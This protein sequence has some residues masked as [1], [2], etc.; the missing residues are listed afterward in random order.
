M[1]GSLSTFTK[2]ENLLR[3]TS[4]TPTR[5]SALCRLHGPSMGKK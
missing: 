4:L 1:G 3:T 2:F 5:F